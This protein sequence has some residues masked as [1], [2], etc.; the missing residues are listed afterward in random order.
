[1]RLAE[2]VA[3]NSAAQLG[4]QVAVGLASL[5]SVAVTARYLDVDQYGSLLAA[6]AFVSI[7]SM[8]AE[9]GVPPTAA[10]AMARRPELTERIAASVLVAGAALALLSLLV[11][12]VGGTW[13]YSGQDD[14]LTRQAIAI[15]AIPL[16]VDPVRSL[17]QARLIVEQRAFVTSIGQV[18][19]RLVS[20]AAVLA[21]ALA[22]LG[23][24]AMAG[25]YAASSLVQTAAMLALAKGRALPRHG[26][27]LPDGRRMFAA[28]ASLGVVL[29]IG[30]VY[31]RLDVFLLSLL[32]GR[33]D[34]AHY[35]ICA[36]VYEMAL[37]VPSY[38]MVTLMPELA[39]A[40]PGT[41]RAD[42]LVRN[43]LAVMQLLAFPLL[44]LALLSGEI[45]A[46]IAGAEY[47]S[48]APVLALMLVALALVFLR[49][50]FTN[51]LVAYGGQRALLG[52]SLSVLVINLVLNLALVPPF[53]AVGAAVGLLLSEL[54]F[55][56]LTLRAYSAFGELPR[57]HRPWRGLL[58]AGAMAAV[59][60][61]HRVIG[62]GGL[63]S[64][65]LLASVGLAGVGVYAAALHV[66]GALPEQVR[67]VAGTGGRRLLRAG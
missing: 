61:I 30:L 52:P 53:G 42:A 57:P 6:I 5:A 20:L 51:A 45:L 40:G 66:L 36:R 3:L 9:F 60:S 16:L 62:A 8:L 39:R 64:A 29:L 25:A 15:L 41:P 31:L 46:V 28:A 37:L 21:V 54:A 17:A 13:I 33:E 44:A 27:S 58:A 55:L 35:G 50:V 49:S 38:V 32:A 65:L 12:V 47:E 19:G 59:I 23:P 24:V 56:A 11:A 2:K 48:A 14:A 18:S 1:M 10:R 34:V 67:R 22:D 26:I 63:G 43:A 7:F 4:G